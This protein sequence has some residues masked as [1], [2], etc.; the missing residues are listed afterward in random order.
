MAFQGEIEGWAGNK[1][2]CWGEDS[3]GK[4]TAV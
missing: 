1:Q 2:D 3:V 4:G